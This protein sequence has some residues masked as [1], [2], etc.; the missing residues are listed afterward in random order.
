MKMTQLKTLL[1][2]MSI[3]NSQVKDLEEK[4][5]GVVEDLVSEEA[6]GKKMLAEVIRKK[7]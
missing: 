1:K 3:E 7:V 2:N 4:I 6:S 5:W